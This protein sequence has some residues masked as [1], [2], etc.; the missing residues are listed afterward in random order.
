NQVK[1]IYDAAM[2][3]KSKGTPLVVLAGKDYGMGSSRDWAAEGTFLLGV[4]AVIAESFERIHRSNLVGMCV[5][6]LVYQKGENAK[7]LGLTG[8]EVFDI[9]VDDNL[10]PGQP[11]TVTATHPTTGK[12]TKFTTTCRVDTPVEVQYYRNG[13]IL[14]TVVR[15]IAR[16]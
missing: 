5:L 14:H 2:N 6:P 15:K 13:G 16:G 4:R 10:K 12:V 11:V 7:T 1:F 8:Q 3:Y 9:D